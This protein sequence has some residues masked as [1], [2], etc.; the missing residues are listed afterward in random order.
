[1]D[2]TDARRWRQAWRSSPAIADG[3]GTPSRHEERRHVIGALKR[4]RRLRVVHALDGAAAGFL[5]AHDFPGIEADAMHRSV[6]CRSRQVRLARSC[7]D[8]RFRR[9]GME[10]EHAWAI[11]PILCT[12]NRASTIGETRLEQTRALER[13]AGTRSGRGAPHIR[14][15][16]RVE[17]PCART[18]RHRA[19]LRR[20]ARARVAASHSCR[21]G[22]ERAS[23]SVVALPCGSTG[24]HASLG[25]APRAALARNE[26]AAGDTQI[27]QGRTL[28]RAVHVMLRQQGSTCR[29]WYHGFGP[30][31]GAEPGGRVKALC[32]S[33]AHVPRRRSRRTTAAATL[34]GRVRRM[35]STSGGAAGSRSYPMQP[36]TC[37]PWPPTPTTVWQWRY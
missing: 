37:M 33:S 8:R 9:R 16:V 5:A 21:E 15:H 30:R 12:A 4:A 1:V 32:L 23:R 22:V 28:D 20:H 14:P 3:A 25:N 2:R 36:A 11:T 19:Q 29:R 35:W 13:H 7:H 31:C 27:S 6:R 26:R 17:S 24:V 18:S 34:I 10:V